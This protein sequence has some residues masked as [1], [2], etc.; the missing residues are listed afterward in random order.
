MRWGNKSSVDCS[1]CRQRLYLCP[2]TTFK[3]VDLCRRYSKPKSGIL[4]Y[5]V[6][7]LPCRSCVIRSF[8]RSHQDRHFLSD[9][10]EL[11]MCGRCIAMNC[12]CFTATS[13]GLFPTNYLIVRPV[14]GES[15]ILVPLDFIHGDILRLII[16]TVKCTACTTYTRMDLHVCQNHRNPIHVLYTPVRYTFSVYAK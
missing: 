1:H 11:W 13:R 3:L 7:R 10:D 16:V 12:S 2:Q 9:D 5:S 14:N 6:V 8:I 4:G 15:K